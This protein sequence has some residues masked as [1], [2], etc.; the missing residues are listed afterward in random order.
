[1][2]AFVMLI[3]GV[4][5][6]C[7]GCVNA[8]GKAGT[9]GVAEEGGAAPAALTALDGG[10]LGGGG[11]ELAVVVAAAPAFLFTHFFRSES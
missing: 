6:N 1:M 3:G 4:F 2:G 9:G 11:F 8:F 7:A 10:P 5:P